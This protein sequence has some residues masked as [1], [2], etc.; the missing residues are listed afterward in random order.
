MFYALFFFWPS[1]V[2]PMWLLVTLLQVFIPLNMALRMCAM[3]LR[4]HTMQ[5][6]A[7]VIILIAIGI[8]YFNLLSKEYSA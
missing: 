1:N 7:G 2:I 5:K 6:V 8:N 4:F 3:K